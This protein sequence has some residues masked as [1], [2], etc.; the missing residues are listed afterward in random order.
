MLGVKIDVVST[1]GPA[2]TIGFCTAYCGGEYT[3][4]GLSDVSF[5]AGGWLLLPLFDMLFHIA[6]RSF[7]LILIN[8][9]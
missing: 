6:I 5:R 2:L 8:Q 9:I 4:L 3:G 1:S 7:T